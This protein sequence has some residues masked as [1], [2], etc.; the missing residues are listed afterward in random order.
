L[1]I[2][3]PNHPAILGDA[4]VEEEKNPRNKKKF[5][6]GVNNLLRF[7]FSWEHC[8]KIVLYSAG[9]EIQ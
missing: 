5:K 9:T 8:L 6:T 3:A 7:A 2:D 4:G 1:L